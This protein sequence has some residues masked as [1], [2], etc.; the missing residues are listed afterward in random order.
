M[1]FP[2]GTTTPST[3]A[4]G[5][6][7]RDG[8]SSRWGLRY[9]RRTLNVQLLLLKSYSPGPWRA[10]FT[11]LNLDRLSQCRIMQYW[12]SFPSARTSLDLRQP[13]PS[14]PLPVILTYTSFR[15]RS[16]PEYLH[17][18]RWAM[19]SVVTHGSFFFFAA[20]YCRLKA[21]TRQ[22]NHFVPC[23]YICCLTGRCCLF[24]DLDMPS[25]EACGCKHTFAT[26][27]HSC[28]RKKHKP[29]PI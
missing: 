21:R 19:L 8:G 26:S 3:L 1:V 17:F 16:I 13:C 15:C 20:S 9:L 25:E 14:R 12:V 11:G 29:L 28:R 22:I 2:G 23:H 4:I 24:L 10:R 27:L 6:C 7:K 18:G 5:R